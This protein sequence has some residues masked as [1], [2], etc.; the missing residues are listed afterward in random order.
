MGRV[1]PIVASARFAS[2]LDE[3]A[4]ESH[5]DPSNSQPTH[6]GLVLD[7]ARMRRASRRL[8]MDAGQDFKVYVSRHG[9][10]FRFRGCTADA[11]LPTL[12]HQTDTKGPSGKALAATANWVGKVVRRGQGGMWEVHSSGYNPTHPTQSIP[13]SQKSDSNTEL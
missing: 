12:G 11:R 13:K 6:N 1:W 10:G 3:P 9:L 8:I 7:G 5:T 4:Y 2:D